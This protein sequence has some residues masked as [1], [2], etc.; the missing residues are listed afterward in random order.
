MN[1]WFGPLRMISVS[2]F[3][4]EKSGQ[5]GAGD[6]LPLTDTHLRFVHYPDCQQLIIWLPSPGREY[7]K[8]RL[9]RNEDGTVAEE[10]PVSDKLNGSTQL[11]WDT[12]SIEPGNYRIEIFR[13]GEC[14]HRV[15]IEKL[16]EGEE[17]PLPEPA[18]AASTATGPIVYRDGEGNILPEEDLLLREKMAKQM[19]ATFSRHITYKDEGRSGYVIYTEGDLNLS[20]YYEFGGGKCI[21]FMV[22][23]AKEEWEQQTGLPLS[24]RDDIIQFT[25][26]TVQSEKAPRSRV[27]ISDDSIEFWER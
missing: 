3:I 7:E 15:E 1:S 17:L 12:L 5:E 26:N 19:A 2:N 13:N 24:R 18:P 16:K 4:P 27:K 22:V 14:L 23:P 25:A 21:A 9:V 8:V 11:L 20:F 10:W 6:C